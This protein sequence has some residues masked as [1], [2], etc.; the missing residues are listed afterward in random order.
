MTIV[1]S[2]LLFLA[3][4]AATALAVLF[5]RANLISKKS[6]EDA[7]IAQEESQ[8]FEEAYLKIKNAPKLVLEKAKLEAYRLEELAKLTTSQ[9]VDQAN[10]TKEAILEKVKLEANRIEE[11]A[12]LRANQLV[13]KANQTKEAILEKS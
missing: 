12:S 8:K 2:I 3:I 13:D 4:F 10:Q 6:E 1:L 5:F 7:R 11:E 9:L